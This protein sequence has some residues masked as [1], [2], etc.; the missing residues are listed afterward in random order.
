MQDTKHSASPPRPIEVFCAYSHKDEG[1]RN[2]LDSHLSPLRRTGLV[3]VWYDRRIS[4]G[5]EWVGEINEHLNRADVV[6]LLVSSDF[7]DSDYCY[8]KEMTRAIQRHQL[9]EARV[10]PV[11]LRDCVW[12]FLPFSKLLALPS[13]GK[14]VVAWSRRDEAFK[15]VALGIRRVA[16]ELGQKDPKPWREDVAPSD[17]LSKQ[18]NPAHAYS[19]PVRNRRDLLLFGPRLKIMFGPPMLAAPV[20]RG[21]DSNSHRFLLTDALLDP[22]AGRTILTPDAVRRAL[23][24]QVGETT[25]STVGGLTKAGIYAASLQFP[26]SGFTTIQIIEVCCCEILS[27]LFRCLIGRD[28]LSRWTFTYNGPAGTWQVSEAGARSWVDP[29]EG[30]GAD[31]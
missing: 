13:D 29:P 2:E 31:L 6:L 19:S 12:D 25:L 18:S 4:P 16:Q 24:P 15:D 7:I 8:D 17:A 23:L 26:Y 10:I 14:P 28:V 20:Q 11:I 27:P 21:A 3:S 30:I 5:S 22:G 9:R 1:L